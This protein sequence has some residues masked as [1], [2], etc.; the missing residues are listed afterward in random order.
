MLNKH[1]TGADGDEIQVFAHNTVNLPSKT[2]VK[3]RTNI[4]YVKTSA[5]HAE[6]LQDQVTNLK[7]NLENTTEEILGDMALKA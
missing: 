5:A 6:E 2:A 1:W 3:W 7:S 4:P